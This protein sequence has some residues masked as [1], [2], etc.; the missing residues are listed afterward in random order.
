[1]GYVDRGEERRGEALGGYADQCSL[2]IADSPVVLEG[3]EMEPCVMRGGEDVDDRVEVL[4]VG[5]ATG[6]SIAD[7]KE[8]GCYDARPFC[9]ACKQ[10]MIVLMDI[11][12]VPWAR[13]KCVD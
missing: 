8:I 3:G 6:F 2:W 12:Y 13:S 4:F 1:M 10:R 7:G 5:S 11:D 9:E